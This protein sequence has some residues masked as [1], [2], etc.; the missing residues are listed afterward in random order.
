MT[1]ESKKPTD[2]F[3]HFTES[4]FIQG[5][6]ES[7]IIQ[8][9]TLSDFR[10]REGEGAI[11][12]FFDGT[13]AAEVTYN[14]LLS[15]AP[16]KTNSWLNGAAQPFIV[17]KPGTDEAP[18]TL[19]H[20]HLIYGHAD[21]F[22]WCGT[23][24]LT[25]DTVRA[26]RQEGK[27]RCVEILDEDGFLKAVTQ[28]LEANGANIGESRVDNVQYHPVQ[29]NAEDAFYEGV[30]PFDKRSG[31]PGQ[32]HAFSLQNERRMFWESMDQTP[33]KPTIIEVPGVTKYIREIP[34]TDWPGAS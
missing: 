19:E 17:Q 26:M 13:R 31:K 22:A 8:I 14:G 21:G 2:R 3:L 33:L 4:Q 10:E 20:V 27:D 32:P 12:D 28:G 15:R 1:S 7:G 30:S 9:G 16:K 5:F 29:A 6:L 24:F 11:G 18:I 34:Q 25:V 23:R